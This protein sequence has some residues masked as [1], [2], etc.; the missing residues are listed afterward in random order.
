MPNCILR[1]CKNY[2]KRTTKFSDGVTFHK[3]PRP[4]HEKREQW[5]KFVQNNRS[6]DT[7]L[8]SEH[9]CICSVHFREED[10]YLTKTGRRYLKKSAVPFEKLS[11]EDNRNTSPTSLLNVDVSDSES[12]FDTPIQIE[13]KKELRKN[14]AAK[15]KLL[16]INKKLKRQCRYLKLKNQQ[17]TDI[18]K[19]LKSKLVKVESVADNEN[20]QIQEA[21]VVV[22]E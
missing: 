7:W 21:S 12:I 6:E 4:G 18:I 8:P 15:K 13:L 9:T 17:L 19:E 22:K 14:I 3:F 10:F 20:Q 2:S 11:S 1:Y 16:G 5:I